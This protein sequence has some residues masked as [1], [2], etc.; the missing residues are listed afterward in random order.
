MKFEATVGQQFLVL[1]QELQT[2][3]QEYGATIRQEARRFTEETRAENEE[4]PQRHTTSSAQAQS[5]DIVSG[6]ARASQYCLKE[7]AHSQQ[8]ALGLVTEGAEEMHDESQRRSEAQHQHLW[9]KLQFA[10]QFDQEWQD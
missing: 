3:E 4:E 6:C 1:R 10:K 5:Y 7:L 8:T 2:A 9:E